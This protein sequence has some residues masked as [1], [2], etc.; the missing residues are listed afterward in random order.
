M[1]IVRSQQGVP[2]R[3]SEE[4]WQHVVSRHPE[5]QSLHEQVL[6]TVAEPDFIQQGDY[7][8]LLA[9]RLYPKTP[10]TQKYV[11]AAYREVGSQDGFVLTAYLTSHPSGRRTVLWKR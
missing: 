11:V 6:E 5:M 7:G 2:I 1:L 8:E 4:R 10:L 9:I 3:L